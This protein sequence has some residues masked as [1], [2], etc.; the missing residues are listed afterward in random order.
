MENLS[1]ESQYTEDWDIF[2][3]II[4]LSIKIYL[5]VPSQE[6]FYVGWFGGGGGGG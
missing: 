6:I 2:L 1:T 5:L 4:F 3:S